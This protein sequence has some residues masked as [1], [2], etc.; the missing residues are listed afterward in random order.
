MLLAITQN[1]SKTASSVQRTKPIRRMT[2][3]STTAEGGAVY[4]MHALEKSGFSSISVGAGSDLTAIGFGD[5]TQ[6]GSH[7][8]AGNDNLKDIWFSGAFA[9]YSG[10]TFAA[11]AFADVP[12][13]VTIHVAESLSEADRAGFKSKL[14]EAGMPAT[15]VYEYYSFR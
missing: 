3:S 2:S 9:A 5:F 14:E 4:G 11:D 1:A 10:R 12:E 15:A 6:F 13:N 8:L 7:I